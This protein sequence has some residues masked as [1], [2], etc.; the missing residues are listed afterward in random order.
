MI[1]Y[2]RAIERVFSENVERYDAWYVKNVE[3]AREEIKLVESFNLRGF[4]AE[5][6]SGTCF[7]ARLFSDHIVGV[8]LS[9]E[10]CKFCKNVRN[11][12]C[13]H[14]I[15]ERLPIRSESL[16]YVLIIVTLCFIDNPRLVLEECYRVLKKGGRVLICIVPRDS[17]FGKQYIEKGKKGNRFYAFAKFYT[18]HEVQLL[19]RSCGLAVTSIRGALCEESDNIEKCNFVCVLAEKEK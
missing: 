6:G 5:I 3:V 19:C 14:A 8:D 4:G 9:F 1:E 17:K 16:D 10:M 18:V 13:V 12:E 15:G 7:F 2:Y 11:V